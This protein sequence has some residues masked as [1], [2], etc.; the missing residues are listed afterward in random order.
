MID[1]GAS[2]TCIDEKT[3]QEMGL[4]VIDVA[5]MSSASHAGID[6]NVYPIQITV[7]GSILQFNVPRAMGGALGAQ[8]LIALIGRD[9]L[10]F[11]TLFYNGITGQI[12]LSI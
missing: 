3:A 4:P 11:C 10:Q 12:T 1:T 6:Q 7:A 2:N 8:G 5:K 9:V